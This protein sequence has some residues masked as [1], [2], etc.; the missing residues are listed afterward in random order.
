MCTAVSFSATVKFL[1]LI[2]VSFSIVS[3]QCGIARCVMR[4]A[5]IG[6]AD[7]FQL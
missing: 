4:S 2:I 6:K 5:G 3:K 1:F 7:A